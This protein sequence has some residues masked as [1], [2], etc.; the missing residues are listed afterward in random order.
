MTEEVT[1]TIKVPVFD[2]QYKNFHKWWIK[3]QAYSR[4]KGFNEV[5]SDLGIT[6]TEGEIEALQLKP[7]HGS[8]G[9]GARKIDEEKQ[10]KLG[11]KNLVAMAHLTMAFESEALLNNIS[12]ACSTDWPGGM[13]HVL[14]TQIKNKCAPQDR[15]AVAE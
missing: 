12:S 5:L 2:G 3:F 7:K 15:M 10:L 9:N 1:S 8:G 14:I 11:K 13:A 4:V 6:I